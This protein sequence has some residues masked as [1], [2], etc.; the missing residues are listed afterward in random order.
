M[1]RLSSAMMP[2]AAWVVTANAAATVAGAVSCSVRSAA[3][4]WW[5]R[6][7]M[8]RWRPPRLSADWMRSAAGAR[9]DRG[10][11]RGRGASPLGQVLEGHERGR[12]VLAQRVGVAGAGPDQALMSSSVVHQLVSSPRT[13]GGTL[14]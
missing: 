7:A 11:E 12:V 9:P 5:A 2:T 1:W 13:P 4:I 3:R 8:L 14:T 10:W 6:A